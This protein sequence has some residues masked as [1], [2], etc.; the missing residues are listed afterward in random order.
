MSDCS[1]SICFTRLGRRRRD[2]AVFGTLSWAAKKTTTYHVKFP[3]FRNSGTEKK[4]NDFSPIL[5]IAYVLHDLGDVAGIAPF[6]ARSH[7]QPKIRRRIT[8]NVFFGNLG[9]E[10][11]ST[12]FPIL[13]V[14]YVLHDLG[15]VA[16]VRQCHSRPPRK[17]KIGPRLTRFASF[18]K[19]SVRVP[20]GP[21]LRNHRF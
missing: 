5:Q 12:I 19:I 15:D 1:N 16:G 8:Q 13:Q 17:S 2:R 3:F 18:G 6:L 14:A 4:Q 21:L 7:G 11:N 10:K 20:W 9:I